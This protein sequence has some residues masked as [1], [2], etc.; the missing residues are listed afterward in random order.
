MKRFFGAVDITGGAL[1]PSI[2]QYSIPVM[3][4]S[5]IQV[6]FGAVDVAVLGNLA[7]STAVASVGVTNAI[8]S[9]IVTSFAGLGVGVT[10]LLARFFGAKSYEKVRRTV[11]TAVITALVTGV[12]IAVFGIL[13]ARPML[14]LI[15]CPAENMEGALVYITIYFASAPAIL[16]YNFCSAALR[17]SGDTTRPLVYIIA[18]GLLNVVLNIVLCLVLTQKV[19]AVAIATLASQL[20]GA[21]LSLARLCRVEGDFR[22]SLRALCF[23]TAIFGKILRIGM[24]AAINHSL[25]S[26][27]NVL[28]SSTLNGFGSDAIAGN[29]AATS[30]ETVISAFFSAFS[31][32]TAVFVGQN[33]GAG[34]HDRV[35]KSIVHCLWLSVLAAILLG[36]GSFLLGRQL[37]SL[38]I[39]N[40]TAAIEYG[41]IRLAFIGSI[42]FVSAVNST[43]SSALQAF[44]YTS[45][46]AGISIGTV[47]VFRLFWM[48]LIYPFFETIECLYFCYTCSWLLNLAVVVFAFFLVWRRYKRGK[49][50]SL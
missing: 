16:L 17:V 19:M 3:L 34:R 35:K 47:L 9:L 13:L 49:L 36:D 48:F 24:P 6:L 45:V 42:Y 27:S 20:L 21:I 32:A 14:S 15:N 38:F 39:P 29:T 43:L 11:S 18:S 40:Q 44:G 2:V 10:V 46:S 23:D 5:V 33:L 7:S 50:R 1:V 31:G 12:L 41:M 8:T 26:I 30:I 28:I 4:A 37:L 25:Y 22:L